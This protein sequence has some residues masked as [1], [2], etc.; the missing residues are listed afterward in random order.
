[1]RL[2][3]RLKDQMNPLQTPASLPSQGGLR[4]VIIFCHSEYDCGLNGQCV[5]GNKAHQTGLIFFLRF[6]FRQREGTEKERER[7][8]S[9][10][11]PLM[12]PPRGP[13]P[14]PRHVP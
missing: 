6:L 1:M 9:V 5:Q 12:C 7:N 10:W 13:G 2:T 3:R 11:W 8:I 14:Q 4:K